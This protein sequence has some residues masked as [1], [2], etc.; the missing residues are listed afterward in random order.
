MKFRLKYTRTAVFDGNFSADQLRPK[1][2]ED[3]VH[4]T[5]GSGFMVT[6]AKYK[7]HLKVAIEIKEVS[8][9]RVIT[10]ATTV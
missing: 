7:A 9:L 5:N 8:S 4:L 10:R 2:P 1:R 6:P 3:N